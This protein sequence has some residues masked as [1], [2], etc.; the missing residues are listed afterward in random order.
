MKHA[1]AIF[2]KQVKDTLKNI[3]ILVQFILF[4]AMTVILTTAIGQ[5]GGLP[6]G[7]FA[8]MFSAMYVGMAPLVSTCSIIAEEKEA[9][10]LR[11]LMMANVRPGEYLLGAGSYVFL[12]CALG[13]LVFCFVAGVRGV[14]FLLFYLCLLIG[15]L[16]SILLG[17]GLGM[18]SKNQ[19]S[20]TSLSMPFMLA[21]SFLPMISL[22]NETVAKISRFLYTQQIMDLVSEPTVENFTW[23]RLVILAVNM[24][25]GLA[26]F[27]AAYRKRGLREK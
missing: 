16:I 6:T 24:A 20:A 25:V 19:M 4:P 7:Y 18:L 10:T 5:S 9:N 12:L 22:F 1:L 17:A 11:V 14:S 3:T 15:I 26:I 27:L 23:D 2:K 8:V 13:S 21:L